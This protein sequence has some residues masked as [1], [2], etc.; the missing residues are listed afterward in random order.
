MLWKC[1]RQRSPAMRPRACR[2][3][4]CRSSGWLAR[5]APPMTGW[6]A[7]RASSI[8]AGRR[9]RV[10]RPSRSKWGCGARWKIIADG[11]TQEELER[12]KAQ[13]IAAHVYQRDSMM[14]QAREIGALE[15]IGIS[16]RTIDL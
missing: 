8:S 1:S 15:A 10:N 13:A 12:A 4:L 7:A 3:T 5:P 9:F 11:V 6:R 16:H 14:Y 2:A